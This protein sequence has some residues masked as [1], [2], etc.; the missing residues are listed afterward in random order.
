MVTTHNP[1]SLFNTDLCGGLPAIIIKMLVDS[2][3]GWI[4]LFPAL[5]KE[6]PTGKIEGI[7]CHGQIEVRSLSWDS[8]RITVTLRSSPA[9]KTRIKLAGGIE[10]IEVKQGPRSAMDTTAGGDGQIVHSPAGRDV[11]FTIVRK[12][13]DAVLPGR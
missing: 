11:T 3:P 12:Q 8:N 10:T 7:R 4:E 2:Q 13:A 6:W 9:Q 5:P 1:K